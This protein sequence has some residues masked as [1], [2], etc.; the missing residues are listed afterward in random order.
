MTGWL[1]AAAWD[2]WAVSPS[3]LMMI[4]SGEDSICP[5]AFSGWELVMAKLSRFPPVIVSVM[6][7]SS[8]AAAC[9]QYLSILIPISP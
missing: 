5:W 4:L 8:P 9:F 2:D 7:A 3:S 1:A 6:M